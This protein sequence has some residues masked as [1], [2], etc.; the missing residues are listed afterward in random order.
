MTM[1]HPHALWLFAVPVLLLALY[2]WRELRHRRPHMRVSVIAPWMTGRSRLY[3]ILRHIP[4]ALSIAALCLLVVALARP[5]SE[6]ELVTTEAEGIDIVFA[7]DVSSSMLARDFEPN[8]LEAAKQIAVEFIS[9]RISD[10][11]GIVLF[12]GESYTLCPMTTDKTTLIDMM[13]SVQVGL[14]DDGTAIGNGLATAINA[15]QGSDAVS[16]VVILLTDGVNNTGEI[17][18]E[19]AAE[20]SGDRDIKVYTIGVGSNGMAAYPVMTPWGEEYRMMPVEIDEAVLKKIASTTGGEYFRATDN[21]KLSFIFDEID[22]LEKTRVLMTDRSIHYDEM[23]PKLGLWA[24]LL[25]LGACLLRMLFF[26][27]TP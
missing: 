4:F 19:M 14:I 5:R 13:S 25:L 21:T 23:F 27:A 2:L 9:K 15:L 1:V 20:I 26:K 10:R 18:P 6:T 17:T 7:M 16:K 24:M 8:R 12:A 11:M 3:S 22:R